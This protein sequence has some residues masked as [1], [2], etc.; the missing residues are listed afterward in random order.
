MPNYAKMNP[1]FKPG[2]T[3]PDM[4]KPKDSD[5]TGVLN[6]GG[7]EDETWASLAYTETRWKAEKLYPQ[8]VALGLQPYLMDIHARGYCVI[9]P[10]LLMSPEYQAELKAALLRVSEKRSGIVPDEETGASHADMVFPL[11]QHM[12]FITFED[13]IFEPILTN[14]VVLGLASYV[15]G[16]DAILS[17]N[18][19]M[20]KG[21]GGN[22]TALHNDNGR[23]S[24]LHHTGNN[25]FGDGLTM[26]LIL[27]DYDEA[28]GG[29]GFVPGSHLFG[30]DPTQGE[31]KQMQRLGQTVPVVAKAGSLV[32]WPS[33]TWHVSSC[34]TEPGLRLTTLMFWV[35][36]KLQT[37]SDFRAA[38]KYEHPEVLKRNPTAFQ[39]IMDVHGTFPF[40]EEDFDFK[41]IAEKE[42]AKRY[43]ILKDALP[44]WQEFFKDAVAATTVEKKPNA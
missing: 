20:V 14:P 37:Q 4:P 30:R 27:S 25:G 13:P 10:E 35:S 23:K 6:P 21:P 2:K 40:R 43:D 17:L 41:K 31:Y 15:I 34:R 7:K 26:N 33:N 19:G 38:A 36:S 12:R 3:M 28:K 8:L 16:P 24:E 11:G 5:A 22:S 9:P 1:D 32:C 29:L 44:M 18:D 42:K 39:R